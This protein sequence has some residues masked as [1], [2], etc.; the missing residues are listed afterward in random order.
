M[1][2]KLA[3][4]LA[5]ALAS[6]LFVTAAGKAADDSAVT[7]AVG[8]DPAF[9]PFFVAD[10]QGL[11]KKYGLNVQIQQHANAGVAADA[12]LLAPSTWRGFPISICSF[13]RRACL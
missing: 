3:V 1:K 9:A 6:S 11:F 5:A 13:A 10:A 7:I 12:R 8:V 2:Y 4:A